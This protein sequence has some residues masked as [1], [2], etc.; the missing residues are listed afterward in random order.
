MFG[1]TFED[2]VLLF[3]TLSADIVVTLSLGLILDLSLAG[4][5]PPVL[6][7]LMVSLIGSV[8]LV[9]N[10]KG[11]LLLT[12]F[13]LPDIAAVSPFFSLSSVKLSDFSLL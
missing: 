8:F 7:T 10:L 4:L 1:L 12:V 11:F 6:R 9:W 13:A 5:E 3:S 2:N